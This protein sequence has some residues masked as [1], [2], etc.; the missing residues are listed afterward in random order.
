MHRPVHGLVH[1]PNVAVELQSIASRTAV[2]S[3]SNDD[4][5]EVKS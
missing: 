1:G 3:Q 5:I 4:R 2:E